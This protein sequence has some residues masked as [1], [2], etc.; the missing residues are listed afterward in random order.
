MASVLLK[1]YKQ[2]NIL[3]KKLLSPK[4]FYF[5]QGHLTEDFWQ[6][7]EHEWVN[8]APRRLITTCSCLNVLMEK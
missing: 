4:N 5:P 6:G 3:L 7:L 8:Y 2:T 1:K